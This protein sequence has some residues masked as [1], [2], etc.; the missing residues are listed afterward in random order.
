MALV[1]NGSSN[2]IT[3]LAVGGLP[4]GI[5]DTDMIAANAVTAPKRGAGAILQI[6]Q[7]VKTDTSS[8]STGAYSY[9]NSD[10]TV[11]ITP[12]H[13]SNKILLTGYLQVA[14]AGPQFNI[15][16]ALHKAGGIITDYYADS[17][18]SRGRTAATGQ[19][20]PNG[21]SSYVNED[22]A[23]IPFEFLDTAGGTSA[24]TYG[25][26]IRNPSS[27]TRLVKIN[28]ANTDTDSAAGVRAVS[29]ITAMEVAV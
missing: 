13:T 20:S 6:V 25:V 11:A 4:D 18:S 15:G 22:Q 19:N 12:S 29:V 1:F 10:L 23:C 7:T 9:W 17:D 14:V 28:Y 5:V 24:I 26:A 27:V 16:V 3:G 21:G 2:V 8:N